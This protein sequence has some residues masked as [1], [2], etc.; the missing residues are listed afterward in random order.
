MADL[1]S[2]DE[3]CQ[4][5]TKPLLERGKTVLVTTFTYT[6]NGRFDVEETKTNLGVL[7]K[8]IL[9]QTGH[10]R[11][12]HPLFSYAALGPQADIVIH[13]GKSAFGSDSI[14]ERLYNRKAAFLHVGRPVSM[15][16]TAL[17]H[18]EHM[19]GATYRVHKGFKTEVFRGSNYVGTDYTA[20]LRR[21]DVPGENFAFNFT[22]AC[23]KIYEKGL[24]R[25]IGSSKDLNNISMYSYDQ[26]LDFLKDLFYQDQRIFIQSDFMEY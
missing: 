5:F 11:S 26:T 16:N 12:E 21:R 4:A 9:N 6:T 20:F 18:V 10:Q 23:D 25:E 19:C 13:V 14:F 2:L 22:K 24:I 8:W 7:N 1:E 3:F 15:G 17:H